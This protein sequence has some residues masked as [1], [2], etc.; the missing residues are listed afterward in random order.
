L[1]EKRSTK[2]KLL[3]TL[4]SGP[5]SGAILVGIVGAHTVAVDMERDVIFK[6]D[7]F[8]WFLELAA[9]NI[10][11]AEPA[12]NAQRTG[13]VDILIRLFQDLVIAMLLRVQ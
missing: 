7:P 3:A 1:A 9:N 2:Q 6:C 8:E 12:A 4:G 10:A 11:Q 5:R 13:N